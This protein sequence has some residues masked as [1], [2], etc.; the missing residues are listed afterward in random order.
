MTS[1]CVWLVYMVRQ[2]NDFSRDETTPPIISFFSTGTCSQSHLSLSDTLTLKN[3]WSMFSA[4]P[5]KCVRECVC[6]CVCVCVRV[7]AK[8][9]L[10]VEQPC[11]QV[12]HSF[13]SQSQVPDQ[14]VQGFISEETLVHCGHAGLTTDVPHV[15]NHRVLLWV[16]RRQ[17]S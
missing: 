16:T 9:H 5:L 11:L 8:L 3:T 4:D 2:P 15:E 6:V 7:R 1:I 12:G 17:P 14:H 10:Y 13:L